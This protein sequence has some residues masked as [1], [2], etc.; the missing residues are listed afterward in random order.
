MFCQ[1]SSCLFLR[2]LHGQVFRHTELKFGEKFKSTA[3]SHSFSSGQGLLSLHKRAG[4]SAKDVILPTVFVE[5]LL[6]QRKRLGMK[7]QCET[8]SSCEHPHPWGSKLHCFL[9]FHK[10]LSQLC[11]P[12][13]SLDYEVKSGGSPFVIF[14]LFLSCRELLCKIAVSAPHTGIGQVLNGG[15]RGAQG[16]LWWGMVSLQRR[17]WQSAPAEGKGRGLRGH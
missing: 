1:L 11:S 8:R 16:L 6:P 9:S 15:G 7:V 13:L 4:V 17:R 3:I 14:F 10:S 2:H 5:Q 12:C